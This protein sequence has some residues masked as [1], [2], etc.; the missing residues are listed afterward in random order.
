MAFDGIEIISVVERPSINQAG[1]LVNETTISLVT[2]LENTGSITLKTA[3]FEKMTDEDLA[4]L[5]VA[6]ANALDRP[7]RL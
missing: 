2:A 3:H 5:I 7:H 1:G 6:K 4:Q